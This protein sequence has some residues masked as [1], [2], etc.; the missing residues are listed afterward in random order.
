M[1][2]IGENTHTFG[3]RNGIVNK[4]QFKGTSFRKLSFCVNFK[5]IKS[6]KV[7]IMALTDRTVEVCKAFSTRSIMIKDTSPPTKT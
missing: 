5:Y 6:P 3:V 4:A 7:I 2:V 1:V